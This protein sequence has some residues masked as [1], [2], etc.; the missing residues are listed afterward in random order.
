MKRTLTDS[1]GRAHSYLRISLTDKCNLAC[2]Y[3]S[4]ATHQTEKT[5]FSSQ[6]SVDELERIMRIFIEQFGI[7]KIRFTGGEPLVRKDILEIFKRAHQLKQKNNFELCLTSNGIFLADKIEELKEEGLDT[8]NISL[9]SLNAKTFSLITGKDE[10]A[11][12]LDA[13]DKAESLGFNPVKVNTVIIRDI[14]D[15]ELLDFVSFASER[16][17][18]IRFI[19]FMPFANNNWNERSL[20]PFE[21]MKQRIETEFRLLP[22]QTTKQSVAK[23]FSIEGKTGQVSFITSMSEHFCGDCNRLRLTASGSLKVC[24]FSEKEKDIPLLPLLRDATIS[25]EETADIILHSLQKKG[26]AHAPLEELQQLD[27]NN[28]ISIGG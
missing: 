4:P 28:M 21:E 10:L 6:L 9:D 22:I 18:N 13:I 7:N 24:L 12:V 19:E 14:N 3:C 1:F 26:F 11:S 23:N 16:N 5:N 15:N 17:F 20:V 25:D 8:I 27:K 2:A